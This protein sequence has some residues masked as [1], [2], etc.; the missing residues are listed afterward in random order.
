M[1]SLARDGFGFKSAQEWA[2][3]SKCLEVNVC[4]GAFNYLDAKGLVEH[5]TAIEWE[6]DQQVQLFLMEQEGD[7]FVL[8]Y[9]RLGGKPI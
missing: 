4:V 9:D 2:G 8:R 6:D 5:L 1:S 7:K 3:G